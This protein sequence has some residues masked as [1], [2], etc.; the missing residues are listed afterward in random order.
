[1]LPLLLSTL[2]APSSPAPTPPQAARSV[3]LWYRAPA[4]VTF[5]NEVR[6]ERSV[7]GSYFM[8]CGFSHGYFGLQ[9]LG[10]PREKVIL[11]SVW[12]PGT[13]D[14]PNAVAADQR[15]EVLEHDPAV[16][17][18]RFGGEGTGAQSFFRYAWK[19]GQTYRFAVRAAP[20]ERKTAYTAFFYINEERRWKRLATFRT[21]T[22]GEALTGLYSFVEDFRRDGR[23]PHERR[24]AVYSNGWVQAKEGW[25][26]SLTDVTFTADNTPLENINAT[27]VGTGFRLETGGSVRNTTPL[28]SRLTR[29]PAGLP[30]PE[31]LVGR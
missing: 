26:V 14:D 27:V 30:A 16:E 7:N 31:A 4:A 23:S 5:V 28:R 25:W 20:G 2:L 17:V 3:H 9:Q 11:F 10:S 6:V 8:V 12:D 24:S 15:V 18:R 13:Q 29:A 21:R 22:R 19:V 1:M